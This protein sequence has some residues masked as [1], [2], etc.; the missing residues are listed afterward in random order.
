[1]YQN[2]KNP[3]LLISTILA[4]VFLTSCAENKTIEIGGKPVV[5]E[6][7][8]W[9]NENAVKNDSIVYQVSAGNVIWSILAVET[10]IVPIYLTGYSLYE[11][12]R[13]K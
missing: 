1:M 12:V 6:P 8:G 7:Y 10:I 4:F 13:K 9:A 5:V 3:L 11:P 2:K